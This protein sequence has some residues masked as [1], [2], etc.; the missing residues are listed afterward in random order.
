MFFG[1]LYIYI[2]VL[3]KRDFL[4]LI[5]TMYVMF[6]HCNYAKRCNDVL[7]VDQIEAIGDSVEEVELVMTTMNGLPR[8]WDPFIKGICSRR[9]LTKFSRLWEDCSQEEARLEAREEKLG[10]EENQALE[11]HARKGKNKV[12]D[13]P[14]WKF[15]KSQK[16]QKKQRD[17]SSVRCYTCQK[18]RHIARNCPLIREQ[19]K[20]ARNKR[21]HANVVEDEGPI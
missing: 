5:F 16:Y 13:R 21:H 14:P 8:S 9:K 4:S 1:T 11:A 17:Y 2:E 18:V 15:Q 20:K 7:K 6:K 3:C 19:I 10:N 12:E